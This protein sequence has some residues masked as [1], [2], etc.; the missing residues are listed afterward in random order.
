MLSQFSG[1]ALAI[2]APQVPTGDERQRRAE[3]AAGRKADGNALLLRKYGFMK[4]FFTFL[5]ILF[6]LF[7]FISC[8][9][10]S[11]PEYRISD[12][13]DGIRIVQVSDF[14][15]N[16]YGEKEKKLVSAIKDCR[17][18]LILF[19]GDIFEFRRKGNAPVQNVRNLLEGIQGTAPFFYVTGN[20]EYLDYHQDEWSW[21]FEE[22]GGTVL[23]DKAVAAELPGGTLIIAGLDDP[24]ADFPYEVKI[25]EPDDTDAFFK[26]LEKLAGEAAA[27]KA[28]INAEGKNAVVILMSHRPEYID[29]YL[30]YDFDLILSGHAHGGQWRLFG[31][32]NGLYAPGQGF[33]PKYSGGRFDFDNDSGSRTT[34]IVSRG[35]SYQVPRFPR[36]GNKPELPVVI[37][38]AEE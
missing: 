17:P 29:E 15:S 23:K 20:H 24:F 1:S 18:D 19:T 36:L 21:I 2:G 35:L 33:F 6:M 26:R 8:R 14:H 3:V 28:E 25:K 27:L 31:K 10:L 34:F 5:S 30:K 12:G 16:D 22:Y 32:Q 38:P 7:D 11:I 13:K 4:F 37:L 9:T